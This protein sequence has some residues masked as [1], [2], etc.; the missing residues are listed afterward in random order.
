MLRS[1]LSHILT[2]IR[3][4]LQQTTSAIE[5]VTLARDNAFF[6]VAFSTTKRG[7]ELTR[8]L[9]QCIL[10]LPNHRGLM[11]NFQSGKTQRDGADHILT[12]P[13]DA[14]Y[15]GICPVRAVEQFVEVG[16]HVGWD[17]STGYMFPNI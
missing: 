15:I 2:P 5:R 13:Y 7:D 1:H 8:T 12:V 6:P 11:F 16:K 10:R 4:A 3:S 17:M 9:I 14:D